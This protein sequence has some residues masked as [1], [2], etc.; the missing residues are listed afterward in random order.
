AIRNDAL[1]F[2]EHLGEPPPYDDYF[3]RGMRLLDSPLRNNLN[4]VLGNPGRTLAGYDQ[5]DYGGFSASVRVMHAQ[6]HDNG[7]ANHRELQ[8]AYYFMREG[9]PLI[10][11]DG[12]NQSQTC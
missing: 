10:Y 5:R 8:N 11:S 3:N 4:N 12:Y 6:S 7:Y 2:G 9:V 1:I